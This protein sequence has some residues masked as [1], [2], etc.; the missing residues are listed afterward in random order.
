MEINHF[1]FDLGNTL[2]D[3]DLHLASRRLAE[4]FKTSEDAVYDFLFKSDFFMRFEKGEI[5][6]VELV[7]RLNEHFNQEMGV[8][9]F[10]LMF[11]PI[12]SPRNEMIGLIETLKKRYE[13]S[14]LSNTNI[15]HS[16]YLEENYPF[17]GYFDHRFYSYSLRALK[18]H[19]EIF[20]EVLSRT[21]S[22]PEEC[23][24]IDDMRG[25]A[26]GAEKMGIPSIHFQGEVHLK[27]E[28]I[29]RGLI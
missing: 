7:A 4:H 15:L 20:L 21:N 23:L 5:G 13:L 18:P 2:V 9:S 12:F 11:S 10:D 6:P 29:K 28:L 16:R 1:I 27:N 25:H 8:P 17:L 3:F 24:F 22:S 26:E 14:L 19:P